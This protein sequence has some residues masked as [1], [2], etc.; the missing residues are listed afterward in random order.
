MR[1]LPW[2]PQILSLCNY[3]NHVFQHHTVLG[4]SNSDSHG[5]DQPRYAIRT[6]AWLPI[7]LEPNKRDLD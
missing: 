4:D 5:P 1:R 6:T 7:E 2:N 3:G